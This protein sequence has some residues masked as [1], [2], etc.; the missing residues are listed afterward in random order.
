L[1]QPIIRAQSRKFGSDV[2]AGYYFYD[3]NFKVNHKFNE[4]SRLFLST[5]LGDDR[6]Y[7]DIKESYSWDD[8]TTTSQ[9][10]GGLSWGN[11]SSAARWN[12]IISKKVFSN[13]TFTYCRFRFELG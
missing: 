13:T 4:N 11:L 3:L 2:K 10:K 9:I 8:Q 7:N 1:A 5:Y 6:A 12:Q